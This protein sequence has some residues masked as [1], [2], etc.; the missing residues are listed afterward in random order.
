M[1]TDRP[2][3]ENVRMIDRL[4]GVTNTMTKW[5]QAG[6]LGT[7]YLTPTHLIF[8]DKE[9]RNESWVLHSHLCS[10]EKQT[11]NSLGTPLQIKCKNF[12]SITFILPREKDAYEV[13][14]S[15]YKLSQ[16][17]AYED[18]YCFR[19]SAS[20]EPFKEQRE[21]GWNKYDYLAEF[22]RQ[23]APNKHWVITDLNVNYQLCDTYPR[24]LL[25]P[26]TA[27]EQVLR[28]SA[29][30]RSKGRLPVLSYLNQA[31]GASICRCSQPLSGPFD[32]R[33]EED[34]SLLSAILRTREASKVLYIVDTRPKV[35]GLISSIAVS[36][37]VQLPPARHSS[38]SPSHSPRKTQ[39]HRTTTASTC[40][41]SASTAVAAAAAA[42]SH[43]T[44]SSR[45][46]TRTRA[47]T[48]SPGAAHQRPLSPFPSLSLVNS[49]FSS[50]FKTNA[51]ANKAAG[52]GFENENYYENIKFN[53]FGIEN[54]HVMRGS[55]NRLLEGLYQ[56]L[57]TAFSTR[58]DNFFPVVVS[59]RNVQPVFG[60]V[61]VDRRL[62]WLAQARQVGPGSGCLCCQG[63]P[64]GH[65]R[66]RALQRR[67]GSNSANLFLGC[68]VVGPL[69]SYA[70]RLPSTDREGVAEFRAQVHGT[71]RPHSN[72]R[73]QGTVARLHAIRRLHLAGAAA[74][75]L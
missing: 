28:A 9:G 1:T 74:V 10:I 46:H 67:L 13:L 5:S 7:L 44:R 66:R 31:N 36:L 55:L 59:L 68:T 38:L 58:N 43:A 57:S 42:A 6:P 47:H 41:S 56:E 70:E 22:R 60:C 37:Y 64:R 62:Q 49:R 29:A 15:L 12:Q 69:L 16:P 52:K 72:G 30:F 11:V 26:A 39:S 19:Y 61:F 75:S 51:Y 48:A 33:S 23:G 14:S 54:I 65:V 18:L 17:L 53:F 63:D 2:Q 8:V 34:K 35:S 21:R 32:T 24:H 73:R 25:V 40:S 27:S 50:L 3:I 71:M 20:N 4:T 45:S